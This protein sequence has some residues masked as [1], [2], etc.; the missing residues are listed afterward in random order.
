MR[1]LRIKGLFRVTIRYI[2]AEINTEIA[3]D[4]ALDALRTALELGLAK[5][6]FTDRSTFNY[7]LDIMMKEQPERNWFRV[8]RVR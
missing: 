6:G 4:D 2:I 7:V 3:E 1:K 8:E 5:H